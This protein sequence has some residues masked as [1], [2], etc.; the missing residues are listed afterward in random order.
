[1]DISIMQLAEMI[2]PEL[3]ALIPVIWYIGTL[4]KR[5]KKLEN[6]A[7]PV[8]LLVASVILSVGWFVANGTDVVK[9]SWSGMVQRALIAMTAD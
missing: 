9:A 7:I 2:K 4:L 3:F 1:M 8:V 5:S 6:W